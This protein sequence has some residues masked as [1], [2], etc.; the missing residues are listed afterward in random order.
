M[1]LC[2][3]ASGQAYEICCG[4]VIAGQPAASAEALMR[5]RY[6]AFVTKQLDHILAS[7]SAAI[8]VDFD[9]PAIEQMAAACQWHSL[10]VINSRE[11]GDRGEVEFV[12]NFAIEGQ[13]LQQ[14]ERS[15]FQRIDGRW[16]YVGGEVKP[17]VQP[18]RR[19]KLG[20]NDPCPC[21]S[22]RKVKKCCGNV[23]SS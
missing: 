2:P 5:S 8:S 4:P 19:N 7:Q 16:Q 14:A 18:L 12:L 22:G 11:Q 13:L 6:T 21:G 10:Q 23:L 1:P 3:C 20:R 15:A 17:A 9:R